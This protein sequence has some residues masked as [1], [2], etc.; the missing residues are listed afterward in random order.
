M[1]YGNYE[2]HDYIEML[3]GKVEGCILV[4]MLDVDEDIG[5]YENE[6]GKFLIENFN[7]EDEFIYKLIKKEL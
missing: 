2:I 3:D 5:I 4:E 1:K 7:K 6:N